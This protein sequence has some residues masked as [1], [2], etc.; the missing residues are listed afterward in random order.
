[1][2]CARALGTF[3]MTGMKATHA[4]HYSSRTRGFQRIMLCASLFI[5]RNRGRKS[6]AH[7]KSREGLG[8]MFKIWRL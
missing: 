2:R 3:K 1:V 6:D 7:E 8:K 5:R 4:K